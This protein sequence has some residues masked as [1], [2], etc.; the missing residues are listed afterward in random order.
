MAARAD[1]APIFTEY[2]IS[3]PQSNPV[4]I[5]TGS[6]GAL[7]FNEQNCNN[8]VSQISRMSTSGIV[9]EYNIPATTQGSCAYPKSL[10]AGPDGAIWFTE[11]GKSSI[12]R[13]TSSGALSQYPI[14]DQGSGHNPQIIVA[15][16]DGALW[17]TDQ[18][19]NAIGRVSTSGAFTEYPIP[20]PAAV[21][22]GITVGSDGALWFTERQGAGSSPYNSVSGIGR[23]TTSGSIIEYP[24]PSLNA[25][26]Y[27]IAAGSDGALWFT[28]L[29]GN[30]IGRIATSG[31]VTEYPTVTPSAQPVYITAGPGGDLWFTE[32][33]ANNIASIN[34]SG[35]ITEYPVPT[36]ASGL[37]GITV[38]PDGALWF[39][40]TVS[41]KIGRASITPPAA[42]LAQA[43][44]AGGTG[45][46]N[47]VADT[48]FS[49]GTPYT[50]TAAVETSN[51]NGPAPQEVYQSARYGN[52]AYT[53]PNLTPNASYTLRLDF[54]ELYWGTS[55][56]GSGGVGSRVFNV[57][58]NESPALTNFD[59]F[60]AAGGANKAVAEQLPVTADS[61]GNVTVGFTS[62][63]D[64]AMVNGISV[65][66]GTLPA[67]TTPPVVTDTRIAAGGSAVGAFVADTDFSGGTPY[68]STATVDTSGVTN[69][70]PQAVY[71]AC[72]YGNFIYSVPNFAPHTDVK[73][74]LHFNELYWGTPLAGF[75]GG[76]GSRVFN[77][78]VNGTPALTNFDIFQTAGAANKAIVE[79]VPATTDASGNV[80]IQFSTVT[81]NAM[82][83][84]IEIVPSS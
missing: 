32:G 82:V 49:G 41:N 11:P 58:V 23:I 9:T 14:P 70:A 28:E 5:T 67:Q 48:Q 7:W 42:I 25:S 18:S 2:P 57:T 84:G 40:E 3:T 79:E 56:S 4:T 45:S 16:P 13:I 51:V 63:T 80:T 69:P 59:I 34:T 12:G 46:G 6:D 74:R 24:I 29:S 17:F 60:K 64:N 8:G 55:L 75:T 76:A 21:P 61:S 10:T 36:A 62:V 19:A 72:R 81:D 68:S 53:V 71:Q 39:I 37:N 83:N 1:T 73:V 66:S 52:F 50:S 65:Y 20:T 47:F 33:L 31:V 15:G 22:E 35:V 27:S 38:G 78:S 43:I 44:D 26:P 54:N 30:R 77:V